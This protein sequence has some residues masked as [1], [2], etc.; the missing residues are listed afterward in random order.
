M[1]E[2]STALPWSKPKFALC[3][4]LLFGAMS[5]H[6]TNPDCFNHRALGIS[7]RSPIWLARVSGYLRHN[8]RRTALCCPKAK[9]PQDALWSWLLARATARRLNRRS[10]DS[11]AVRQDHTVPC[12]VISICSSPRCHS[13]R[14][15]LY[16]NLSHCVAKEQKHHPRP[17]RRMTNRQDYQ[18]SIEEKSLH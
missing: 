14:V 6:R 17:K 11:L 15:G 9:T 2:Q 16:I 13:R 18:Q 3:R 12:G 10:K 7:P 8:H 1:L 4:D 5:S